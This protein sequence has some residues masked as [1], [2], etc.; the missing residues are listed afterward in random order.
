MV[1]DKT[2]T[3]TQGGEPKITSTI[4]RHTDERVTAIQLAKDLE[5]NST[6]PLARAIVDYAE[7]KNNKMADV[8]EAYGGVLLAGAKLTDVAETAGRGLKGRLSYQLVT[9]N[10]ESVDPH[11][12]T[13]YIIG[14]EQWME[15]HGALLTSEE[16][17]AISEWKERGESVV[18]FATMRADEENFKV[19]A[20]FGAS[21]PIRKEAKFVVTELQKR[22]IQTWMISGDNEIT[23]RAVARQVGISEDQV[24]AGVL[25]KDKSDRIAW[26]QQTATP[27]SAGLFS[28]RYKKER[29]VVAMVGDGINDAPSLLLQMLELL[30]VLAVILLCPLP[31]L[32][33]LTLSWRPS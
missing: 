18:L 33:W 19:T 22:G 17:D 4:F 23:A 27:R 21:D 8:D 7:E 5:L 3:L 10:D 16:I 24:I 14:N 13:E 12:L 28:G 15:Q 11:R 9:Q 2:G 1:F 30:L 25:P 6:H 26:L 31:N 20:L 32:F 29:A